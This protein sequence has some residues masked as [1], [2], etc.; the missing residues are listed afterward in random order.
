MPNLLPFRSY[1]E[2]DVVNL[3]GYHG[4]PDN[5]GLVLA[6]GTVVRVAGDTS[7]SSVAGFGWENDTVPTYEIGNVGQGVNNTVS[8]RYGTR[9]KLAVPSTVSESVLGL[10]LM[11]V[12]ETD[13]N[14]EKLVYHPRKAAEIGAVINGHTV[15]VLTRGIVTYSGFS[16]PGTSSQVGQDVFLGVNGG[17]SLSSADS[18]TRIGKLL[19][20]INPAG[21]ALLKVEL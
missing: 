4:T 5:S 10:V 16:A 3:F 21:V 1:D 7:G 9:A 8:L 17:L 2:H 12:R 20:D 13:E 18:A 14:G 6:K 19:S 15:P 11:D